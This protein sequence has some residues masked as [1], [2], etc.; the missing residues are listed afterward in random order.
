MKTI[1]LAL[2]AILA[3]TLRAERPVVIR[4]DRGP[5]PGSFGNLGSLYAAAAM[6]PRIQAP[7]NIVLW[8]APVFPVRK[9]DPASTFRG[10]LLRAESGSTNAMLELVQMYRTGTGTETNDF[11]ARVWE[12]RAGK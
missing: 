5:S 7:T 4:I 10:V 3:F 9:A 2:L 8:R 12:I 11:E 6:S 1:R